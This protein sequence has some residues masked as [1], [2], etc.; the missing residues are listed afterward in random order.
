MR[1]ADIARQ[2]NAILLTTR[3]LP[4]LDLGETFFASADALRRRCLNLLARK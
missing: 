2:R 1:L 3:P 4:I